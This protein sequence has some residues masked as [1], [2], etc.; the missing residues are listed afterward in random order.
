MVLKYKKVSY[1]DKQYA[2]VELK[3]KDDIKPMIVDWS[4]FQYIQ[5]LN[6]SW[7]CNQSNLVSCAHTYNDV[8][9][10]IFVHDIIMALINKENST[11][12]ENAPIVH[13]NTVGFDNR[14]EN[15]I[16][17]NL[18]KDD[19]KNFKKKKRT[20]TLPKESGISPSEL[21]TYVWYLKPNGSHGERFTIEI[22]DFKWKTTS[23]KKKSLRY[24][25]EEAKQYMRNLKSNR[26]DIFE[27]RCMNGEY[28]KKG[29]DLLKSYYKI[30]SKSGYNIEKIQMD[31]ITDKYLMEEYK[32]ISKQ[33][34]KLLTRDKKKK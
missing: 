23:S 25:L 2:I 5:K 19:N 8:T 18:D 11:E 22:G 26:P 32:G 34:K 29:K 3:H 9:K 4:D 30:A 16:Y 15:L 17:D 21:P 33:E 12:K 1:K 27:E 7:K 24:K 31:G 6:K 10:E 13:I 28:T 14:R 20:I